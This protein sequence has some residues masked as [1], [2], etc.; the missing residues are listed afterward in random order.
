MAGIGFALVAI[1]LARLFLRWGGRLYEARRFAAIYAFASP[2][3]FIAVL[4]GWTVTETGRQPYIVY[5]LLKTADTVAP[6]AAQA[7]A[8]SL[9]LFVIVYLVLLAAFFFYAARLVF[10]GPHEEDMPAHALRPGADAAPA[11]TGGYVV[12]P[13]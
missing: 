13:A 4:A 6:V 11:R 12:T 5:G 10:R 2:L 8:S 3:P 1:A 7:V 9:A